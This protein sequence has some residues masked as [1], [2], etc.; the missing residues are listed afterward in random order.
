MRNLSVSYILRTLGREWTQ[1]SRWARWGSLLK[2][3][4]KG[5]EEF[6]T[7]TQNSPA[8][9]T[10]GVTRGG[11]RDAPSSPEGLQAAEAPTSLTLMMTAS[12]PT[13]L[14]MLYQIPEGRREAEFRDPRTW[15]SETPAGGLA[16]AGLALS[17]ARSEAWG[18]RVL[19]WGVRG[20]LADD[21]ARGLGRL[22]SCL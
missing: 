15:L 2:A 11:G 14:R 18:C 6:V 9:S 5:P 1:G 20:S 3:A 13:P 12:F 7:P 16:S 19:E 4:E 17:G 21:R 10:P 22:I 8:P